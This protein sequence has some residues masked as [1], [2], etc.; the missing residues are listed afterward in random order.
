MRG[1]GGLGLGFATRYGSDACNDK[2]G[3][4]SGLPPSE[5]HTT[6]S[7]HIKFTAPKNAT[8]TMRECVFEEPLKATPQ[9]QV[10]CHKPDYLKN[11]LDTLP[12]ISS[13]PLPRAPQPP[14]MTHANKKTPLK[15]E[16]E[17]RYYF[18][19]CKR[20]SHLFVFFFRSKRDG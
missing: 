18:E 3:E 5:K 2:V 19:Y 8:S 16:R 6:T 12:N 9:K 4:C 7:Y 13:D 15:R 10:W 20:D 11:P 14:K 17:V 1:I